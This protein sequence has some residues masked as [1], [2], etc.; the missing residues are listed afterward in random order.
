VPY[1]ETRKIRRFIIDGDPDSRTD[2]A[3]RDTNRDQKLDS[4]SDMICDG[5]IDEGKM[6]PALGLF[7]HPNEPWNYDEEG[8]LYLPTMPNEGPFVLQLLGDGTY[9]KNTITVFVKYE[10]NPGILLSSNS[11]EVSVEKINYQNL[12]PQ[13]EAYTL[14]THNNSI[15]PVGLSYGNSSTTGY[16]STSLVPVPNE[17]EVGPLYGGMWPPLF[18]YSD[19]PYVPGP[20]INHIDPWINVDISSYSILGGLRNFGNLEYNTVFIDPLL[21]FFIKKS[22]QNWN[23]DPNFLAAIL[24]RESTDVWG[25]GIKRVLGESS[26]FRLYKTDGTPV[27]SFGIGQ[28]EIEF[29]KDLLWER[30]GIY[31]EQ[32]KGID[33]SGTNHEVF[34]QHSFHPSGI[35]KPID[36]RFRDGITTIDRDYPEKRIY[37]LKW[38]KVTLHNKFSGMSTQQDFYQRIFKHNGRLDR[39]S[40]NEGFLRGNLVQNME[41]NIELVAQQ[42]RRSASSR[43]KYDIRLWDTHYRNTNNPNPYITW[44]WD[45]YS[46]NDESY[47]PNNHYKWDMEKCS[48]KKIG[49]PPDWN[50][51]NFSSIYLDYESY[52]GINKIPGFDLRILDQEGSHWDYNNQSLFMVWESLYDHGRYI[53]FEITGDPPQYTISPF[54]AYH[55]APSL[56]ECYKKVCQK[57]G[58]G[59]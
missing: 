29:A 21:K 58:R 49:N 20:D 12:P 24:V 25:K 35:Y 8:K 36:K 2:P 19:D 37:K 51:Q 43:S 33:R 30:F 32:Q 6:D 18:E 13:V 38:D 48:W 4:E 52:Y 41:F 55:D 11:S 31:R 23:L 46:V 34:F 17:L 59:N 44:I 22:S 27:S 10:D 40:I 45:G 42:I 7:V 3:N 15:N 53:N 14:T 5:I 9:L 28:M 47:D 26:C 56:Y 54:R 1:G 16:P 39:I 50:D 57:W